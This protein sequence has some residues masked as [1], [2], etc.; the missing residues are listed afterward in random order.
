M[1]AE[2]Y[3]TYRP[4]HKA[5][6]YVLFNASQKVSLADFGDDA[7]VTEVLESVDLMISVLHVHRQRGETPARAARAA[8]LPPVGAR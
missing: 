2:R 7:D 4:I 1:M 3:A 6:R 8:L 5:M